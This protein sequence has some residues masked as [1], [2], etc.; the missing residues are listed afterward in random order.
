MNYNFEVMLVVKHFDIQ[1]TTDAFFSHYRFTSQTAG[2]K[3]YNKY[4]VSIV[5]MKIVFQVTEKQWKR[6]FVRLK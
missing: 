6:I 5:C 3:R 2:R 1:L 4:I